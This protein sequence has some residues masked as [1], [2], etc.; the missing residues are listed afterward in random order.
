MHRSARRTCAPG[1]LLALCC[2][3]IAPGC[4]IAQ[5]DLPGSAKQLAASPQDARE[6]EAFALASAA[7]RQGRFTDAIQA[8]RALAEQGIPRAQ[9]VLG[10]MYAFGEGVP[11]DRG[12]A[13]RWYRQAAD[14]GYPPAQFNLGLLYLEGNPLP[15]SKR[16]ATE[17]LKKA[18]IAGHEPAAERL[19]EVDGYAYAEALQVLGGTTPRPSPGAIGLKSRAKYRVGTLAALRPGAS[20]DSARTDRPDAGSPAQTPP[21]RVASVRPATIAA[22]PNAN[23]N[24]AIPSVDD[25]A[26]NATTVTVTQAEAAEH[27]NPPPLPSTQ[28]PSAD[29]RRAAPRTSARKQYSVQL[30]ASRS[31]PAVRAAWVLLSSAQVDLF[32]ALQPTVSRA[33]L[34]EPPG[35]WY[36]LRAGPFT[37]YGAASAWCAA[38]G[39]RDQT[40]E[41]FTVITP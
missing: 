14:H 5:T 25:G 37:S 34:G 23:V 3:W 1:Y 31:E 19:R 9:T 41:C 30:M 28:E 35:I 33:S 32:G 11:Q 21:A 15:R 39:E 6:Q 12:E 10:I 18:A 29:Q 22:P 26:S 24:P 27:P 13:A 36:R 8:F 4:A 16:L 40:L 38:L 7:Y 20:G 17:W 2:F